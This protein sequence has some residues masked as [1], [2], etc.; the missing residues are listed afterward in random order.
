MGPLG[1]ALRIAR[2]IVAYGW[3]C[4]AVVPE[5]VW[6]LLKRV[7]GRPQSDYVP[8][9]SRARAVPAA[10]RPPAG[11]PRL[12]IVSHQFAPSCDTSG[13]RP[14][15]LAEYLARRG[16]PPVVVTGAPGFHSYGQDPGPTI[17]DELRVHEVAYRP[18][19]GE[20][21]RIDPLRRQ[22]SN[23]AL[24]AA[25]RRA[26]ERA[27]RE[28]P[29]P[30]VMLFR[31]VPF[32]YFP[33]ARHFSLRWGIPYVL[34]LGDVWYMRGLSYRRG[35]R[36]G[37]RHLQDFACE[38]WSV[39][40][41]SLVV[42]TTGEQTDVY[43]RRYPHRPRQDFMTMRWGYDA[44]RLAAVP[45]AA[46]PADLLRI[47]IVGRFS[48]Y[49]QRDAD[50]LAHAVR[51]VAAE[52]K[53]EVVHMGLPEPRLRAA[54]ESAGVGG[55]LRMLGML[56]YA[57]CLGLVK[58]ADCGVASPL[59]DVSVPV[60]VYDYM[61]ANRPVLAFAPQGSAMAKLLEPFPGAHLVQSGQQAADA[62]RAVAQ[63]RTPE[64]Q[65]G[66]D[67]TPYSQQHQF[68]RLVDRI[69]GIVSRREGNPCAS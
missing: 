9:P 44:D 36:S 16:A 56:P 27:L 5:L 37:L 35:Q 66:F 33:L 52:R 8:R 22:A 13:R 54:F 17:R 46:K 51:E 6:V 64:L 32:W 30:D 40:G 23:I 4:P 24:T 58:S 68:G 7:T 67:P 63:G 61:G 65:A 18:W 2:R 10:A 29:R 55:Q 20:Q 42:L 38:A 62:L 19:Y 69:G 26:I 12:L 1:Q 45:P 47:A 15:R 57:E 50:G 31:G 59:S 43:R 25:Y 39:D 34:D 14:S 53:V 60:K 11:L 48:V 28:G 41:A 49:D 3:A 21:E